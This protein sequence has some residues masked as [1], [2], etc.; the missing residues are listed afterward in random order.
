MSGDMATLPQPPWR[1]LTNP[2]PPVEVLGPEAMDR[3]HEASLAILERFGLEILNDEAL[4]IL[5][6]AGAEVDRG[7]RRVR[8]DR[9]LVLEQVAKAPR[10]FTLHARNPA[11][12]IVVG[13]NHVNFCMTAG[14]PNCA[15]L[16]RG[17]RPGN[18]A[19]ATALIKLAQS[20]NA[21][22]CLSGMPV[23]PIDL[24]VPIRHLEGHYLHVT[25]TDKVWA[26]SAIGSERVLDAI[27][28]Y[29]LSRGLDEAGVRREPGLSTVVN[30]NSPLRVDG[31]ML[32]GLMAMARWRQCVIV[33]PF[34]L[35]GAMSPVTIAGALAQQNAEAL[36]VIAFLQM[37]APGAPCMYGGFTS[38]V[39]MKSGAPAFGTPEYVKAAM[40]GGQLARRYGLPYRSSNCCAAN[41]P[42]A[43]AGYESEMSIW[44]AVM[45]GA[46][47]L[48]HGVGWMEGGLVASYE[49]AVLDAEMLQDMASFL[50]PVA[51]SGDWRQEDRRGTGEAEPA[52]ARA[53]RVWKRLLADYE[54]PP[55]DPAIDEAIR[56]FIDRRKREGGVKA[57]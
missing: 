14:P 3:L 2:Y 49:K 12:D 30:T 53:N 57:A 39:D 19:D 28:I 51:A 9:G 52:A 6:R 29:R 1:R 24:P 36:G 55:L 34:T 17:R 56:D 43:Q 40:A 5:A 7:T 54:P 33:T 11:H 31:P 21:V 27:E 38:N 23:A 15:D 45:G 18:L 42:D 37:V 8:M 25:L 20:L 44:G 48:H 22:H 50:S 26:P 35:A 47:Y 46:N 32:D 13:E 16:D 41:A 4:A 10:R